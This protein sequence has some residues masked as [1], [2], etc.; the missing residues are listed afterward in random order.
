M[1][2]CIVAIVLIAATITGCYVPHPANNVGVETSRI[3]YVEVCTYNQQTNKWVCIRTR[4]RV[5]R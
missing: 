2:K 5:Q 3:N 4:K 1:M